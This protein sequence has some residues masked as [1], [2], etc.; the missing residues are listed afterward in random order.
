M[1]EL[2]LILGKI[3][4][5]N[6]KTLSSKKF[7]E[8]VK[9]YEQYAPFDSYGIRTLKFIDKGNEMKREEIF[10]KMA[11]SYLQTKYKI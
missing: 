9:M 11:V 4:G 7:S 6:Y 8:V 10:I 5:E 3:L 2:L 1:T